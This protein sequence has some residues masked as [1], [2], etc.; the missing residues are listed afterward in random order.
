MYLQTIQ[1]SSANYDFR[2]DFDPIA[3]RGMIAY[4]KASGFDPDEPPDGEF[5]DCWAAGNDYVTKLWRH[6]TRVQRDYHEHGR[7]DDLE[8]YGIEGWT[9]ESVAAYVEARL[10]DILADFAPTPPVDVERAV[11]R[12]VEMA[13]A[14]GLDVGPEAVAYATDRLKY[15]IERDLVCDPVAV[16]RSGLQS[17]GFL[18]GMMGGNVVYLDRYKPKPKPDAKPEP[19]REEAPEPPRDDLLLSAW[20]KRHRATICLAIS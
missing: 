2:K 17:H 12:A 9:R 15:K 19:E 1:A 10:G 5:D 20:L 16:V 14:D 18:K 13:R 7:L 6:L 3:R 11:S 8:L 4:Q